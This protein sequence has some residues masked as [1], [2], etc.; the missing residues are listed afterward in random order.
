MAHVE[1]RLG[2]AI[3][4]LAAATALSDITRIVREAARQLTGADGVTFVLRDGDLCHY[5]DE[6]AIRPL[7]KGRRFP[8]SQCV[9]GWVMQHNEPVVLADVYADE[10]VL[11]S[12]YRPTFVQSLAMVPVKQA[13]VCA[14]IGA[15]W[16]SSHR[17]TEHELRILEVLAE[18]SARA[19][20]RLP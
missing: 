13:E 18:A 3:D 10:R 12:A 17:A 14:A 8:M 19:L 6:S 11:H 15:Y 7:W 9:S 1:D 5:A 16:A 4:Q 2:E 20:A